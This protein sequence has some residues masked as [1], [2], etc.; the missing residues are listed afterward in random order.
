MPN[1]LNASNHPSDLAVLLGMKIL[2][3]RQIITQIINTLSAISQVIGLMCLFAG[4]WMFDTVIPGSCCVFIGIAFF[5]A[6]G[7]YAVCIIKA[8]NQT[9][10]YLRL[11][12]LEI[13]KLCITDN[14]ILWASLIAC[15]WIQAILFLQLVKYVINSIN[16]QI[17]NN[18]NPVLVL[19]SFN[20]HFPIIKK[21][22]LNN[23]EQ[24]Y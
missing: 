8:C 1:N 13:A 15:G 3:K 17:K 14:Y 4:L 24:S 9:I 6:S 23:Q 18:Q 10:R 19:P 7:F 12:L 20:I 21:N 11:N 5:F 22:K 16:E 2:L